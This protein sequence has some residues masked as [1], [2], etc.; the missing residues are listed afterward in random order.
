MNEGV[1]Q[2]HNFLVELNSMKKTCGLSEH[3][4]G[5]NEILKEQKIQ[6]KELENKARRVIREDEFT[7]F[8]GLIKEANR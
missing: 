8:E 1:S 3:I 4:E 7:E 6:Y 2:I 5:I